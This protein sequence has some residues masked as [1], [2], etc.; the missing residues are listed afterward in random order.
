MKV[1]STGSGEVGG[2]SSGGDAP[3]NATEANKKEKKKK[4]ITPANNEKNMPPKKRKLAEDGT[5]Q[6][7]EM[8]EEQRES[9]RNEECYR[10]I[11]E[12]STSFPH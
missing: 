6:K 12:N 7:N 3:T 4:T 10:M 2:K 9:L 5:T 1:A 11:M 8:T